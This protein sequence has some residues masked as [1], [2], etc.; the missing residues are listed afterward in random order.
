[1][2]IL[3]ADGD[4]DSLDV[5]TYA[6]RREGFQVLTAATGSEALRRWETERPHLLLLDTA[7]PQ[8]SGLELC[9]RVRQAEDTPVILLSER[10]DDDHVVQAFRLGADDFVAKPFSA[11]QL[12]V[13]VRAVWRRRG[14]SDLPEPQRELHAGDLVLDVDAHEVQRGDLTVRLTPTEF[15]LLYILAM[16]VGRVVSGPRLVEYAWGYDESDVL[17]LKTHVCHI[18]RKLRLPRGRPGDIMAVPGVGYRLTTGEVKASAPAPTA[19]ATAESALL[20]LTP[21]PPVL[22]AQVA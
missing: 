1:M 15:R 16:N 21:R 13:R 17:L 6:L 22:V 11:R 5:T 19:A 12:I 4:I 8:I 3:L 14:P 7:L 10:S 20:E 2:R 18:R 9:R